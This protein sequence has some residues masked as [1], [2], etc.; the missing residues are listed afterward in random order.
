MIVLL[1]TGAIDLSSFHVPSTTVVNV[2]KRLSQYIGSIEYAIDYYRRITHLVF[3]ENTN[4]IFDYS[5]LKEKARS[6]G[7][8][9]EVL[10]FLGDY[11]EIQLR[12]K[13]YGE[14]EIIQYALTHSHFL[15]E[16]QSFYKL[17]GR[18][19]VKNMNQVIAT[20]FS[21]SA[22]DYY[23]GKIY[24]RPRDH[25]E[26]I[27]YKSDKNIYLK[28]LIDAY[29]EVDELKYQYLEH[30]FYQR[31]VGLKII[32]FRILPKLSGQ[33]GTTG[34]K[35]DKQEGEILREKFYYSFGIH[36]LHRNF[37]EKSFIRLLS[38]VLG[39]WRSLK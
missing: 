17:T 36:N 7:K 12:G 28:Y 25:I 19:E 26:T 2:E 33:S 39:I 16:C 6:N 1:I 32:S 10:S 38:V 34:T 8:V 9:L 21:E 24:N 18:L 27:F 37:I 4:Y 23:P 29:K 3:C 13:G 31:L 20:T 30:L 15:K 5:I 11:S 22:F 14:G 35:Y